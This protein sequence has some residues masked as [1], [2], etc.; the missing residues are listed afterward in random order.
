M[1]GAGAGGDVTA[2]RGERDVRHRSPVAQ[3]RAQRTAS[4]GDPLATRDAILAVVD[5]EQPPLR[6]F[7]GNAGL[8]M[9]I[10]EYERRISTWREWQPVSVAAHGGDQ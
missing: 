10:A 6:V 1:T 7:F 9:T 5:A 2:V 8:D 4:P 3:W